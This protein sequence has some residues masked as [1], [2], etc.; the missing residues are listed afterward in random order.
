M[1]NE[2]IPNLKRS[3]NQITPGDYT[4]I[5]DDVFLNLAKKIFVHNYY[6]KYHLE[7]IAFVRISLGMMASLF[8]YNWYIRVFI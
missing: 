8:I 1:A 2:P 7:E 5:T 3:F 4:D 6:Q